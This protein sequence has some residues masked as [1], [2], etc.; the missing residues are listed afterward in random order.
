MKR[1]PKVYKVVARFPPSL[2]INVPIR[3]AEILTVNFK[4][5]KKM[6]QF[7]GNTAFNYNKPWAE[8]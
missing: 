4:E 1:T 2:G 3:A 7:V 8:L 5:S 6:I